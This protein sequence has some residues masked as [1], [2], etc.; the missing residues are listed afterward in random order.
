MNRWLIQLPTAITVLATVLLIIHGPIAQLPHY[1]EFADQSFAFGLPHAADV[2]SNVGFA[3]VAAW[4]WLRLAPAKSNGSLGAGSPGYRLFLAGLFLTAL[5]SS[6]YHL[7]PDNTRLVWD[8]LPIA[9]ACAGLLVGVR[10]DTQARSSTMIDATLAAL[11][12]VG[13]VAWWSFTDGQGEGDLRPYLLIQGLPLVLIPLWQT[14]YQAPRR[15]RVGFGIALALY[16]CAKATELYDHE[17]L[18]GLVWI[19]GHTIKHLLATAAAA[20]V[21]GCLSMRIQAASVSGV[22]LVATSRRILGI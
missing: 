4:G 14:I 20:V 1:H 9:L 2:L 8:R 12:A 21:I 19:S 5:G 17:I 18:A 22:P 13:S 16:V 3:V 6:F 15:D 10:G 11:L 7:A